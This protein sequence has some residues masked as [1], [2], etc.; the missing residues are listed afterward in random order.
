MKRLVYAFFALFVVACGGGGGGS[1]STTVAVT[2]YNCM[3]GTTVCNSSAYGGYSGWTTYSLPYGTNYNYSNY[4]ASYGFCGCPAGY[5]PSYN[6]SMGLGCVS[7]QY[8]QPLLNSAVYMNYNGS[9]WSNAWGSPGQI[10]IPQVS[11]IPGSYQ[12]ACQ[13][14]ITQSC[15]LDQTNSCSAGATCQQVLAGSDLGVCVNPYTT[16]YGTWGYGYH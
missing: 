6:N 15:L 3:A 10:N 7:N 13:R 14:N 1:N 12:G 5:F 11:N 4:F 16:S 2:P 9:S 8:L